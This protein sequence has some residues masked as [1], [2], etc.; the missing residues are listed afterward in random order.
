VGWYPAGT[1]IAEAPGPNELIEPGWTLVHMF[2]GSS[3][4]PST[5]RQ[6]VGEFARAGCTVQAVG[7]A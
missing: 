1:P 3:G 5:H 4:V 2:A 7:W 6:R